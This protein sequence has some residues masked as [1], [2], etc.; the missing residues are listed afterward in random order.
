MLNFCPI[1]TSSLGD[2]PYRWRLR[3]EV[4]FA[5]LWDVVLLLLS[6]CLAQWVKPTSRPMLCLSSRAAAGVADWTTTALPSVAS[7]V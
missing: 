5:E 4:S 3:A 6:S 7:S 1:Y 2:V